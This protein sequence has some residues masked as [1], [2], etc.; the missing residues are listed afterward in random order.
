GWSES[1]ELGSCPVEP[2]ADPEPF[3]AFRPPFRSSAGWQWSGP[4]A[5]KRAKAPPAPHREPP[6][7]H[8]KRPLSFP[9]TPHAAPAA[10]GAAPAQ[11]YRQ[12]SGSFSAPGSAGAAYARYKPS[13][14]RYGATPHSGHSGHS[15]HSSHDD[16]SSGGISSHEG[17]MERHKAEPLWHVP[18]QARL[19]GGKRPGR[20]E[21]SGKDSPN[22][23]S[24]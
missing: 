20:Q 11:P 17:T 8:G 15:G 12:P 23:H 5:P 13:P 22:R 3:P 1:L 7:P 21:P 18:A 4:A 10:A 19:P 14:E 24:K 2:K 9:E 16:S 6:P